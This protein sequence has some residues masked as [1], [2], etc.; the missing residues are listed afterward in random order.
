M[1]LKDSIGGESQVYSD[2][3]TLDTIPPNVNGVI[4]SV[5]YNSDVTITFNEGTATLNGAAFVSGTQVTLEGTY[6]LLVTDAAFNVTVVGFAID[7]TAPIVHGVEQGKVYNSGRTIIFNEGTATLNGAAF[8]SGTPVMQDG[9]YTLIVTDIAGNV[10]TVTF[11]IDKTAPT[12]SISISNGALTTTT[13]SVTLNLTG[14]DISPIQMQFSNDGVTWSTAEPFT[15]TKVWTVE[16]SLGTKTVYY[17]LTDSAGYTSAV[18]TATIEL[19]A[20]LNTNADLK[21]IAFSKGALSPVFAP[22]VFAYTMNVA[23]QIDSIDV[24]PTADFNKATT[25]VNGISG[26]KTVPLNYGANT[27]TIEVTAE[28]GITKKTYTVTVN[29]AKPSNPG[30]SNP[31]PINPVPVQPENPTPVKAIPNTVLPNPHGLPVA[32]L[33]VNEDVKLYRLDDAGNLVEVRLAEKGSSL[34]VYD[35]YNGLYK[36]ADNLYAIPSPS[37]SIHIGKGEVRKDEV[38]VYDKDG[39]FIRTIKKGQQYKVYSYDDNRYAIG[40][41]EFIEVQDGVTYVFGWITLTEQL[42]LYKPDGTVERVLKAGERYR[43]Y[44]ADKDNLHLGG[45]F[46]VMRE[47]SMYTFVK[48]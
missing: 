29:R 19:I 32:T 33:T 13:P 1:K 44:Q 38:N 26:N 30:P 34:F 20:P 5:S 8:T 31:E 21:N 9:T 42:I 24:H 18:Y 39:R 3:I 22:N 11:T 25:K 43:I 12:G 14:V 35:I 46:T 47:N 2:T 6:T 17:R 36:L 10:T 7:K 40:G 45:A 15:N 27:I 37:L 16:S 41:G 48:N 28:D 4:D 23:S